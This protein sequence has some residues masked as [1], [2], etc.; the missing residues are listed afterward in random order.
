MLASITTTIAGIKRNS[1]MV[2]E[3]ISKTYENS[4]DNIC[5]LIF[6]LEL[7]HRV[8]VFD[9]LILSPARREHKLLDYLLDALHATLSESAIK[10]HDKT[11][12]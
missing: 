5:K 9:F 12:K 10:C 4:I 6:L 1:L 7:E 3:N 11:K 2:N 8:I